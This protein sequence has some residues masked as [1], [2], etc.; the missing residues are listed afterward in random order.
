M[1]VKNT[2]IIIVSWLFV[3]T[4]YLVM[5]AVTDLLALLQIFIIPTILLGLLTAIVSLLETRT[6]PFRKLSVMFVLISVF[7]DQ[8][9][10]V[11]LFSLD[12]QNIQIT[13]IAPTF[14]FH[15]SH[16]KLGSYFWVLLILKKTSL[17]GN[18]VLISTI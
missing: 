1:I 2:S 12:W 16:N 9:V 13:L 17:L 4:V 15:P 6:K 5:Y 14:Y 7:I 3:A 18:V 10:K 8:V 11:Y